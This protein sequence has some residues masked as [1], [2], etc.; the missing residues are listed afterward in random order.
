MAPSRSIV[1]ERPLLHTNCTLGEG[2]LYDPRTSMLHF[3]DIEQRKVELCFYLHDV[4]DQYH[5]LQVHHLNTNTLELKSEQFEHPITC[6]ALRPNA[7]GLACTTSDGFALIEPDS[8]LRYLCKPLPP[9]HSPYT[10]FND[11]ACDSKGRFVAGTICSRDPSVPGQLYMF[12]PAN[13]SCAVIDQGPFTDSNGLGWNADESTM[14]FTDSLVNRIYAYDYNDGN[15]SNRRVF[16]DPISQGQPEGSFPDGLCIDK[17]GGI[18]S[19]R[20][21]GSKI[22]RYSKDG[23][24]DLEL[25]FPTALNVTACCFGGPNEDQLYVTT[26]H[27]GAC[28]GD[29][30]RQTQHPDS[31]NLFMVDLS[32][33]FR[34]GQWRY[35]FAI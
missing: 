1:I 4:L 22:I 27:C 28:G 31:G 24:E 7:Q 12:D 21:G 29:A 8:T 14:Y 5:I 32:G 10:R 17:E 9:D 3:V 30:A 23:T 35:S 33:Q 11:G 6:L 2:P 26:A 15:L 16:V 25:V 18:W 19:A 34:G 13:G 20:W